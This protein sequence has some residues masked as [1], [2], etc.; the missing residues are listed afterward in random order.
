VTCSLRRQGR[1]CLNQ[2]IRPKTLA[3]LAQMSRSPSFHKNLEAFGGYRK[4][5]V[6]SLST[7]EP[8]DIHGD[9]VAKGWGAQKKR[10]NKEGTWG[11]WSRCY[12]ARMRLRCIH[13]S[14][15]SSSKA[16]T[17]LVLKPTHRTGLS[18]R[19]RSRR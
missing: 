15:F 13:T 2:P 7:L 3:S 11:L 4:R 5:S 14:S 16:R 1:Y 17:A 8:T 12:D 19:R 6:C 18:V 10:G 9:D